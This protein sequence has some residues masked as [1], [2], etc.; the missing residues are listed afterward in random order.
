MAEAII[1][2]RKCVFFVDYHSGM[3]WLVIRVDDTYVSRRVRF[4]MYWYFCTLR[5][6]NLSLFIIVLEIPG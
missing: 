5:K 2:P 6:T 1:G 3:G 4:L